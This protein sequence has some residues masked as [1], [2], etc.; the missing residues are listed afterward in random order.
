MKQ[1]LLGNSA[2]VEGGGRPAG[3]DPMD[4]NIAQ[5]AEG[6]DPTDP[7]QRAAQTFPQLTQEQAA[8]AAAFG[9]E[10]TLD[11]GEPVFD[12]GERSVD[13]FLVCQGSIE[14]FDV[15][16]AGEPKVLTV[17]GPHQFTG[18]LDLFNDRRRAPC[19]LSWSQAARTCRSAMWS[20]S[21]ASWLTST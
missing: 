16:D 4:E 18:E 2:R 21:W 19:S 12:R 8:R 14:I 6:S 20:P 3:G 1:G 15:D 11:A 10:Q 17:H 13:F 7:Y 9:T 5:G